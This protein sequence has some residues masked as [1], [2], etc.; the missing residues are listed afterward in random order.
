MRGTVSAHSLRHT[1]AAEIYRRTGNF[2]AV[3]H[4]LGHANVAP[5]ARYLGVEE[6][7]AL[8]LSA[9]SNTL[10]TTLK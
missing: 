4:L 8:K 1:K 2:A 10:R 3:K 7:H 6:E 9:D 5:T